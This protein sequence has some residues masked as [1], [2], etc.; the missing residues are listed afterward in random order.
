MTKKQWNT[1][2]TP[3]PILEAGR[4]NKVVQRHVE[5]SESL[6]IHSTRYKPYLD[7]YS[8]AYFLNSTYLSGK[9]FTNN[10]YLDWQH[11]AA[12]KRQVN[13]APKTQCHSPT[14]DIS[15]SIQLFRKPFF[16]LIITRAVGKEYL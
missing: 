3:I 4:T 11:H 2:K 8:F 5:L 9:G 15:L 16:I 14:C 1:G 6:Y 13:A 7:H 12:Q 10:T